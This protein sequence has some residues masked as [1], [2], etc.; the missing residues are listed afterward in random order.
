MNHRW[1]IFVAVF[2]LSVLSIGAQTTFWLKNTDQVALFVYWVVPEPVPAKTAV[3]AGLALAPGG[4]R[5]VASGER[6]RVE[7]PEG[8]RL[9]GVFLPW[10]NGLTFR[11]KLSGG[12]ILASQVPAKGTVLVDRPSFQA[13]NRGR[14]LEATLQEWGLEPL[15]F[16]LDGRFDDWISVPNLVEWGPAFAPPG[17]PWPSPMPRPLALQVVDREGALWLRFRWGTQPPPEGTQVSLMLRRAAATLEWPL[18]TVS[19]VLQWEET[20]EPR[21]VGL[22]LNGPGTME[23]WVPWDRL[24]PVFRQAW[25]K[26]PAVW[27]LGISTPSGTR[28]YELG[29]FRWEDLP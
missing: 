23:A 3:L 24:P 8:H 22:A 20:P 21:V 29:S 25:T 26:E 14:V 16:V 5:R 28:T 2:L 7:I 18:T 4:P 12:S 6:V 1:G 11:T 15:H 17:G 27:V 13:S 9:I 10:G 19:P